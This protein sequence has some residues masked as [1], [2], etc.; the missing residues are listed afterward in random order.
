MPTHQP[1]AGANQSAQVPPPAVLVL[2]LLQFSADAVCLLEIIADATHV[3]FPGATEAEFVIRTPVAPHLAADETLAAQ[4]REILVIQWQ[5]RQRRCISGRPVSRSSFV[6]HCF[7]WRSAAS[8]TTENR[9]LTKAR[10]SCCVA[11]AAW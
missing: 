2:Q 8:I 9:F 6:V 5:V 3:L 1:P 11:P 10:F 7:A 4:L